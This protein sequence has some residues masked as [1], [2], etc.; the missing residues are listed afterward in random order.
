MKND[1]SHQKEHRPHKDQQNR[2]N[3]KAKMEK[4]TTLWTLQ[5][6]NKRNL[7]WETLDMAKK[8]KT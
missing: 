4:K 2:N 1:F 3:Q 7:T 8:G 6:T 5:V